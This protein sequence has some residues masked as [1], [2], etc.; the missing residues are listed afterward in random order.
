MVLKDTNFWPRIKSVDPKTTP[1][2]TQPYKILNGLIYGLLKE[3]VSSL[4]FGVFI[5]GGLGLKFRDV[6]LKGF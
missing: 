6:K 5:T 3:G 4:I 1:T 2:E